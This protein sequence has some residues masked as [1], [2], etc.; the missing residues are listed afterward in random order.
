MKTSLIPFW[1]VTEGS[2]AILE[3]QSILNYL[4]ETFT[5]HSGTQSWMLPVTLCSC[6]V[7][8]EGPYSPARISQG[9]E[10]PTCVAKCLSFSVN[11]T[12]S[13]GPI[14]AYFWAFPDT[15]EYNRWTVS[16]FLL[17]DLCF[18]SPESRYFPLFAITFPF[19]FSFAAYIYTFFHLALT[20]QFKK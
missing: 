11:G 20:L 15:S 14:L 16:S 18:V 4:K 5:I 1:Q 7:L 2:S 8:Q 6:S 10:V 17:S 12:N 9:R 13:L 19:N 3:I